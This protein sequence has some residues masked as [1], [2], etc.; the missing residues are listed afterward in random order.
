MIFCHF[1]TIVPFDRNA[2][3]PAILQSPY[4][5]VEFLIFVLQTAIC[6]AD[7]VIVVNKFPSFH[8]FFFSFATNRSQWGPNLPNTMGGEQFETGNSDGSQCL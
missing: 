1:S 2:L 3:G 8:G 4:A 7:N 5:I 6:G